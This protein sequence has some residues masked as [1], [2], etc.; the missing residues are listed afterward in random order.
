MLEAKL[1]E[2]IEPKTVKKLEKNLLNPFWCDVK[3]ETFVPLEGITYLW[4]LIPTG[5]NELTVITGIEE[6][7]T[8]P[9]RAKLIDQYPNLKEPLEKLREAFAPKQE[10]L[11]KK[12]KKSGMGGHPTLSPAWL[13]N[14]VANT[15]MGKAYLGGE[16]Y[17]STDGQW[18]IN[19]KSG[20]FGRKDLGNA[21]IAPLLSM[22]A[23]IL[24][25]SGRPVGYEIFKP[26]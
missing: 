2:P 14:G 23:D 18:R 9:T 20:R 1:P 24:T 8:E 25:H 5:T 12:G 16:L 3:Q 7:W 22:A 17:Q 19:N 15:A 26:T 6:P 4:A 10:E 21:L 13:D 11:E